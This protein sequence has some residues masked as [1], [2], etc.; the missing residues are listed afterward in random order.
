MPP[1]YRR[2]DTGSTVKVCTSSYTGNHKANTGSLLTG[3]GHV[4]FFHLYFQIKQ[5]ET[6]FKQGHFLHESSRLTWMIICSISVSVVTSGGTT[7]ELALS[8]G[9]QNAS[10]VMPYSLSPSTTSG[11]MVASTNPPPIAM[12]CFRLLTR[13]IYSSTLS[14]VK[15]SRI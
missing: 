5:R 14:T 11:W 12:F 10:P 8:S 15:K 13:G 9:P 3:R 4:S 6:S 1:E 7:T 2:L